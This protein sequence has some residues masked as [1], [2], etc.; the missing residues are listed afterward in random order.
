MIEE[1]SILEEEIEK[2]HLIQ[3]EVKKKV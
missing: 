3:E 1:E 2:E